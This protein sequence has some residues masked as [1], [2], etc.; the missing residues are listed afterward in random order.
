MKVRAAKRQAQ[1]E[2][3]ALLDID[4]T[5]FDNSEDLNIAGSTEADAALL[6]FSVILQGDR[7]ESELSEL[8]TAIATDMEKDGI[9]ND[10]TTR[11]ALAD[12]AFSIDDSVS[13]VWDDSVHLW[14]IYWNVSR[15]NLSDVVPDFQKYVRKFWTKEFGLGECSDANQGEVVAAKRGPE[16]NRY[17]C[18]DGLWHVATDLEKDTYLWNDTIPGAIRQGN[19]TGKFY[20][21][22]PYATQ[23]KWY[24]AS[25]KEQQLGGC[26]YE[27]IEG[28]YRWAQTENGPCFH[29][30][31][32]AG[33]NYVW[34]ILNAFNSD[35]LILDTQGWEDANDGDARWGDSI[36]VVTPEDRRCYV[37]DTSAE[38]KGWRLGIWEDCG[39]GMQGCTES[40][41]G[42][43]LRANEGS[44]YRCEPGRKPIYGGFVSYS[45]YYWFVISENSRYIY[46][47]YG[48]DCLD[49]ND[50]EMRLGQVNDVYF[51]CEDGSWRESSVEEELACRE[52]GICH[53]TAE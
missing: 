52:N 2:V 14:N 4:A 5:D 19:V 40:R 39:L 44:F 28:T 16:M 11:K 41:N 21:H 48:W 27:Q 30:C 43:V 18:R 31:V 42:L 53:I 24:E 38:Y 13:Y 47:T 22:D 35:Y 33:G 26:C 7:S 34:H 29:Q 9:W 32:N 37:Y 23:G 8:L 12:W 51:V 17:V 6:A 10:T 1:K 15:W 49:S 20:V 25:E 50:G 36:G 3:F 45:G 46:N